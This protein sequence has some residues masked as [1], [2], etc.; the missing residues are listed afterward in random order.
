ME[1]EDLRAETVGSYHFVDFPSAGPREKWVA[2]FGD[3]ADRLMSA[4]NS[5]LW[6]PLSAEAGGEGVGS[7]RELAVAEP[8]THDRPPVRHAEHG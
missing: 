8:E 1:S 5:W 7:G 3:V 6:C 4:I 2:D